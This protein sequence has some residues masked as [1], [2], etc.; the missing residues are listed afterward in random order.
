MAS[1]MLVHGAW[2]GGWCYARV[3]RLLRVAGH[4][5]FTPTLTGVGERAHLATLKVTLATHVQDV[6][7]AIECEGLDDVILC[8][9]S[10][11]G[12]VV[13]GVA[14]Q[15]GNRIRTLFYLDAFVP[16]DGESLV[17]QLPADQRLGLLD[18][19]K[20]HDGLVPPF[21]AA[22]FAVNEA[23]AA[24][25]DRMCTPQSLLTFTDGVRLNGRENEVRHRTYVLATGYAG[26]SFAPVHERYKA[27]PG[28]RALTI[29]CGH[30]VMVDQPEALARLLL[31]EVER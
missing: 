29:G 11:G 9:H 7:A 13:T 27:A 4:D 24:W 20:A 19:A 14:A 31:D 2:H 1:F 15:L 5:V 22:A 8:G 30:D 23:D 6:V 18:Q 26:G 3:A 25:V 17:D 12:M 10:Y 16:A 28:W 21:P